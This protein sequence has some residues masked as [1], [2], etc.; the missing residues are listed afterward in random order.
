MLSLN[1]LMIPSH[2]IGSSTMKPCMELVITGIKE[3]FYQPG[4]K[5]YENL[6]N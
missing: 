3:K 2:S 6:E 4:Y 1:F 5:M